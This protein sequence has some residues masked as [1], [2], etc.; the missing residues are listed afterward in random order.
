VVIFKKGRTRSDF[1]F[2][3]LIASLCWL[4]ASLG[5]REC[6]LPQIPSKWKVTVAGRGWGRPN[7]GG[8]GGPMGGPA[9]LN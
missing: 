5:V 2:E 9:A 4:W 1:L 7:K 3:L 8:K 6:L